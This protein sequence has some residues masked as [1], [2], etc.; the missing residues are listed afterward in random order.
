MSS[1]VLYLHLKDFKNT[2]CSLNYVVKIK[3]NTWISITLKKNCH[4][5]NDFE[6]HFPIVGNFGI[7]T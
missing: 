7:S 5:K 4:Q 1:T 6:N 2:D 3:A